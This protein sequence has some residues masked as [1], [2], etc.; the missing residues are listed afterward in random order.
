M[1]CK[2]FAQ[3]YKLRLRIK[4]TWNWLSI[5][6]W[7]KTKDAKCLGKSTEKREEIVIQKGKFHRLD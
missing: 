1:V 7:M 6:W 5:S 4:I 3:K 2:D